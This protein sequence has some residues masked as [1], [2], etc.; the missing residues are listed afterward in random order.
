MI[1]KI[2]KIKGLGLVFSSFT[3]DTSLPPFKQFNLIYGWNGS[4]KTTF[5][6]LFD[7]VGGASTGNVEFEVEDEQGV[8]YKQGVAFAKKIRVFNQDYIQNNIKILES[9]ANSISILLG[10]ENKDLI[11]N[12]ERYKKILN[13]DSTD[14]ITPGKVTLCAGYV[15]DNGRK[16]TERDGKFTEI[17]KTIN[18]VT[19]GNALKIYRK[20]D[21]EKDFVLLHTK[22]ELPEEE[23]AKYLLLAKQESLPLVDTL[24]IPGV[25]FEYNGEWFDVS[26]ILNSIKTEAELFFQKTVES[27]V[28]PLLTLNEDIS[29]WVE[30]GLSL[31]KK[32]SSSVCEY[33]LQAIPAVRIKQ[34]ARHFNEADKKLKEDIDA[35]V[36]KLRKIHPVID[37]LRIPD[38]ARFYAALK[39]EFDTKGLNFE[40]AKQQI[41]ANIIKFAEELKC[42]KSKTTEV[43]ILKSNPDAEDFILRINEI[44]EII[45]KHNKTTSDFERIKMEA[46]QKLK[47]HYLSTIFDEIKTLDAEILKLGEDTRLLEAEIVEIKNN[48]SRDMAQVS[49]E[50]KACEVIN[51]SLATFLGHQELTFVPHT[52]KGEGESGEEGEMVTGY[53]I[54]RGDKPAVYLSEGEK[55]AIAFI[56]FVVHLGAKDFNV[57]EGVVVI[58]DPISSLDSNSLYQAFSF[59]KKAVKGGGQVFILTHNF[60]FLKLLMNWRGFGDNKK[61]TGYYMIKNNFMGNVRFANITKMDKEIC[62]YESEYHYLFKILKQMR[63]EQDD[64]IAK[65]YP[66]PNIARKV[67]DSFL[68]FAVPNGRKTYQKMEELKKIGYDEQKIDAIYKFTNDQSHITGAGFDPALVP[69]TK[70]VV[71]ELFEMMEL[72]AP[73][74]FRIIDLA[75]N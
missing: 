2:N 1:S 47:L 68:M 50:H 67:W 36:G 31:H 10:E 74:H 52:K 15:K 69:E 53:Y 21:A 13:G 70:K 12:I 26:N 54:M 5:S 20:P 40:S 57:E 58:D 33:C 56:Y 61:H 60:D 55:T 34:L 23:L 43:L 59:L 11:E 51:S 44:N 8:K 4:G 42:K 6:R 25:K 14:P 72:I 65:A 63:D 7:M 9:R 48:I 27:E 32:H 18:A 75:T 35:L 71:S 19:G 46:V 30:Q 22:A 66:I 62:D 41:L 28:V 17:A 64:S 73:E 16:S 24:V 45:S 38:R 37:S 29:Q 39:D 3:W 49:S